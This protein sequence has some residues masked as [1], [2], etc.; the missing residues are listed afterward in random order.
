MIIICL[1]WPSN[2]DRHKGG[3]HVVATEGTCINL[4]WPMRL[5]LYTHMVR[6]IVKATLIDEM[7]I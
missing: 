7:G 6:K 1:V 3:L 4:T 2:C 5:L